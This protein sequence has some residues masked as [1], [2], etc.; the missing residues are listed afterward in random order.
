MNVSLE[1]QP[2]K[3]I[4]PFNDK[5]CRNHEF[6]FFFFTFSIMGLKFLKHCCDSLSSILSFSQGYVR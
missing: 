3:E 5:S 4:R 2:L 6:N 1:I